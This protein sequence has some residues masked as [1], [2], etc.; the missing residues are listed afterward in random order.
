MQSVPAKTVSLQLSFTVAAN[1][2]C[3]CAAGQICAA[4]AGQVSVSDCSQVC[5]C[6]SAAAREPHKFKKE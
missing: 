1:Q 5:A 4:A 6:H 3:V 2:V